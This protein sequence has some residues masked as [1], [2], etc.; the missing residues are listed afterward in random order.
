LNFFKKAVKKVVKY[1]N[2]KNTVKNVKTAVSGP[3]GKKVIRTIHKYEGRV[4]SVAAPVAGALFLGPVGAAAGTALGTGAR[5]YG[6]KQGAL[7]SGKKGAQVKKAG[8]RGIKAGVMI[9]GG[10]T[11]ASVIGALAG[12]GSLTSGPLLGGIGGG[13]GAVA[14]A[15][16]VAAASGAAAGGGGVGVGT[17]GSVLATVGGLASKVIGGGGKVG[18]SVYDTGGGADMGT[19]GASDGSLLGGLEN[20]LGIDPGT[21]EGQQKLMVIAALLVA[22]AVVFLR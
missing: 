2:P 18:G 14:T 7:A 19:T 12:V 8:R 9:G 13:G 10:V 21:P 1:T 5:Y 20:S 16:P 22:A 15:A 11:G 6:E 17:V 4:A 3:T